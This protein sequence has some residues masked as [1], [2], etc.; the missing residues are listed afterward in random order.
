M[1][2]FLVSTC[3]TIFGTEPPQAGV[4]FRG[5]DSES[6]K[7]RDIFFRNN[8]PFVED[9]NRYE[10]EVAGDALTIVG[11]A[12][13]QYRLDRDETRIGT[14]R[15]GDNG[16]TQRADSSSSSPTPR[17]ASASVDR[18]QRLLRARRLLG[19]RIVRCVG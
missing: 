8:G 6:R 17:E 18:R 14:R 9:G 11:P 12:R 7:T 10:G 2:Y 4:M 16:G 19:A 1:N 15:R 13:F 5:Y 3:E